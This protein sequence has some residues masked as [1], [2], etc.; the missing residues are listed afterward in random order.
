MD[1]PSARCGRTGSRTVVGE[2]ADIK[3]LLVEQG[4]ETDRVGRGAV[5]A[6]G[7]AVDGICHVGLDTNE[8]VEEK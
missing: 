1:K 3:D 7:M 2:R 5:S 8:S 6:V 4:D